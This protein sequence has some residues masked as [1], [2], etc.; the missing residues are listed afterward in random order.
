[1]AKAAN[2]AKY[3]CNEWSRGSSR[4]HHWTVVSSG[5]SGR[6]S[7]RTLFALRLQRGQSDR[8]NQSAMSSKEHVP[9]ASY[10]CDL[11]LTNT[12]GSS[13][14]SVA[15]LS[16]IR[17]FHVFGLAGTRWDASFE[18]GIAT[19]PSRGM[20]TRSRGDWAKAGSGE[21]G[22]GAAA[23]EDDEHRSS[24]KDD[25]G[26]LA[27]RRRGDLPLSRNETSDGRDMVGRRW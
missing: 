27:S 1:M 11:V 24:R 25:E 18:G 3:E 6:G 2:T 4:Q 10:R 8:S 9:S 22:E 15:T 26:E 21:V 12:F 7:G 13:F 16:R 20:I 17:W 23:E 19:W 14:A 5:S